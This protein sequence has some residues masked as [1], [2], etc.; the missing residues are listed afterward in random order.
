MFPYHGMIFLHS[1]LDLEAVATTDVITVLGQDQR[2]HIIK[3]D[4]LQ[5]SELLIIVWKNVELIW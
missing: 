3:R 2:A 4:A 1:V 5:D